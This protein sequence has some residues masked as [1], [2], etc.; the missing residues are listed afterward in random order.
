MLRHTGMCCPNGSLFHQKSL[1]MGPILV[2]KILREG[3]HFTKIVKSVGF[4]AE[5]PLEKGLDLQE[6]IF[7]FSKY[8][9]ETVEQCLSS[10]VACYRHLKLTLGSTQV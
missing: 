10:V 7:F 6:H 1:D 4:E 8:I 9:N 3:S 5:N 2:M